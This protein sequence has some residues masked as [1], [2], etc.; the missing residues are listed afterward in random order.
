[1][2]SFPFGEL[3]RDAFTCKDVE[4]ET[5]REPVITFRVTV[6]LASPKF[7]IEQDIDVGSAGQRF[8]REMLAQRNAPWVIVLFDGKGK[9]GIVIGIGGNKTEKHIRLPMFLI[10]IPTQ[11]ERDEPHRTGE[12]EFRIARDEPFPS[13]LILFQAFLVGRKLLGFYRRDEEKQGEEAF[14]TRCFHTCN[15]WG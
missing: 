4:A 9:L 1:M 10:V 6:G 11:S 14:N 12:L 2:P 13:L 5:R 7:A 8:E 3:E 15:H